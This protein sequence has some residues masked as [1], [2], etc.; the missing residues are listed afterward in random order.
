MHLFILITNMLFDINAYLSI[1]ECLEFANHSSSLNSRTK[2]RAESI[3]I[4]LDGNNIV[5]IDCK[6]P[7]GWFQF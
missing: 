2:R 5:D 4:A 3:K 1:G 6:F 7:M